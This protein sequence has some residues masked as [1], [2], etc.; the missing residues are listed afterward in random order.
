MCYRA[1]AIFIRLVLDVAQGLTAILVAPLVT[2][3]VCEAV[4]T[5][6]SWYWSVLY[7]YVQLQKQGRLSPGKALW[8]I[9]DINAHSNGTGALHRIPVLCARP[10]CWE[11]IRDGAVVQH[12]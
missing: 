11:D 2:S 5:C 9:N 10:L 12:E 7:A 6:A 3:S 1:V 4:Q 8:Q